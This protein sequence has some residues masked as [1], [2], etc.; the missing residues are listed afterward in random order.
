M[1]AHDR[2]DIKLAMPSK[3]LYGKGGNEIYHEKIGLFIDEAGNRIAFTGSPNETRG[4]LVG[5]FESIDVF[6]SWDDPQGRV[7]TK[8]QDFDRLWR[9]VT[10]NLEVMNFPEAD[11][12]KLLQ[13]APKNKPES[14]QPNEEPIS[15][16]GGVKLNLVAK[17]PDFPTD[18]RLHNYQKEALQ[19]WFKANVS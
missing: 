14:T 16:F 18:I 7:A 5:N 2:L 1:V 10:P 15:A 3:I 8:E 6:W 13:F 12:K 17:Y 9:N 19:N 4:G 11:K